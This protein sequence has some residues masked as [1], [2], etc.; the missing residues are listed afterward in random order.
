MLALRFSFPTG[1]YHA[2]P[3]GRNVNEADVAWPPEPWRVLRALVA[4]Y[5]RK[6]DRKRWPDNALARL[7]EALAEQPPTYALPRGAVHTHAR[8]YM[9]QGRGSPPKLVFDAC[10]RLP[11]DAALVVVWERL[12]LDADLY[13][14][15]TDLASGIGYLG[16]AESWTECEAL[17]DWHGEPN[18][19]PKDAGFE[20]DVVRVLAPR[21]AND[22]ATERERLIRDEGQRVLSRASKPLTKNA[23]ERAVQKAFLSKGSGFDTLPARLLEAISL[24]TADWQSTGWSRPPAA[25]E[26]LYALA[27]DAGAGVVPSALKRGAD[28]SR[29]HSLPTVARFILAGRPRPR[30]EDT[31]RIA[32]TMR[33]AALSKFGWEDDP[34]TA[35]RRWNAPS[36]ISGRGEDG[37]PLRQPSHSHAFWLPEDADT[38]GRIDHVS[39]FVAS[40]L[41]LDVREKLDRL[42]R[43]WL[44]SRRR[45]DAGPRSTTADE[46]HM[47]LEGFG[48][49]GDF[50]DDASIFG[51]STRWRSATPFMAA[52]HLKSPGCAGYGRE[53]RRLLERTGVDKRF[54]F[55]VRRVKVEVLGEVPVGAT[56]RRTLHFHR[57]RSRGGGRQPDTAGAFL[58]VVFPGR[59]DGPLALGFGS[60]FGLG[61]FVPEKEGP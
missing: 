41:S 14:L 1:R 19:G 4:T 15:A 20:G 8:H 61:L 51:S 11:D 56:P 42:T 46:W 34:A 6:G 22:Y 43:I 31:I 18:C 21:S 29:E 25:R 12:I 9:P 2:T 7:V 10:Y 47:A 60:H 50:A 27:R 36:E 55:D 40:G 52:G 5:W 59:V 24:D 39:V 30:V 32:E 58:Q 3:W 45:V 38:D 48:V 26:V 44:G 53:L 35:R 33:L 28:S 37:K 57:F 54:D 49:P 13:A 16:R 17:D 23:R